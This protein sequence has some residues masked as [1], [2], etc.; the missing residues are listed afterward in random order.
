[1]EWDV[2][3]RTH[4]GVYIPR[5]DSGSRL[6]TL[7]G[8]RIFPGLHQR[9]AFSVSE[10][11]DCFDVSLRSADEHTHVAVR[12]RVARRC[13]RVPSSP[14]SRKRRPSFSEDLRV[15][16]RHV[17]R[18]GTRGSSCESRSGVSTRWTSNMSHRASL[19]AQVVSPPAQPLL[20]AR[21][22]CATYLTHGTR[23]RLCR[24]HARC[25]RADRVPERAVQPALPKDL[26]A[27]ERSIVTN[28]PRD[29]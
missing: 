27:S 2:D 21:S 16:R 13:R 12:G 6:N 15:T 7:V 23:C 5:R 4:E 29:A 11:D 10:S 9:A 19:A 25:A 28:A 22:S 8:G 24:I 3:G 18:V 26:I 14:T 1:V 20:I 17:A